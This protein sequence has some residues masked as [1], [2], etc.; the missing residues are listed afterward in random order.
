MSIF[1]LIMVTL[2]I[3]T[4]HSPEEWREILKNVEE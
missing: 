4:G 1:L 2:L 3:V